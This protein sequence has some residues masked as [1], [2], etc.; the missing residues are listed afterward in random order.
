MEITTETL[1]NRQL[2]LTIELDAERS[3]KAMR[4]AA[5][6]IARQVNIPGFRKGKA[7][8][9]LILQRYGE[10]TIR[11]EAAEMVVEEVYREALEQEEIVAH[12]PGTLDRVDLDPIT[13]EFV[14]SLP[15]TVELGDYREYRLKPRKVKVEKEEVRQALEEIRDQN[16]VLELVERPAAMEDG[17]VIDLVGRTTEGVEF[18][19]IDDLRLLLEATSTSPAPGFAQ[20]IVGM[21]AGDERSFTL[22]LPAD[23]PEEKYRGQEAEFTV[24][25]KEVYDSTLPDLDDDLARTVGNY[26]SF[27][28]LEAHVRDQLQQAA[29]DKADEEYATQVLEAIIEQAQA[30]YPPVM[31]EKTLD[32]MVEEVER[33][34]KREARLSLDDYLRF[35]GKTMEELREELEPGAAARIKR[36]LVLGEVVVQEG[37]AV[38]ESEIGAR[39]EEVS[40]PW[41]ARAD[42]VRSSLRSD[43]GQ[44]AVRNRLL[45]N[46][47]VQRLVA[48]AKGK[49][50]ERVPAQE[51]DSEGSEGQEPGSKEEA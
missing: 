44:R 16:A 9:K 32:D 39:I 19:N 42:E 29:Q 1:E 15:P 17:I 43:E 26:D 10:D 38:D 2:R 50:P 20:A 31:I 4:R 36:A 23:F 25:V 12:A 46:K 33:A 21:E 40:A 34:V 5:R 8:Y 48:I 7:P 41:G 49:A 35:Q 18:L 30:E 28:E 6:Q 47:A 51:Q 22:T 37:L 11:R 14:I 13:F 24:R 45:T 27:K 3:E